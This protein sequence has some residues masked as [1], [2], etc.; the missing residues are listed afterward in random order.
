MKYNNI[1]FLI[2]W[3][4]KRRQELTSLHLYKDLIN[5]VWLCSLSL[6]VAQISRLLGPFESCQNELQAR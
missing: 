5:Q 6:R 1:D 2:V 4:V 3:Y